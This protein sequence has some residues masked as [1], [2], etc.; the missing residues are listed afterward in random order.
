MEKIV[1]IAWLVVGAY[2]AIGVLFSLA[3]VVAGAKK[4]DPAA[5]GG[6]WGFKVFQRSFP[7]SRPT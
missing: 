2:V 1:E 3:F 4:I 5:D 6:S 7:Y